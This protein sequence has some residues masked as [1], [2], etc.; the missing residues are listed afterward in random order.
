M[1]NLPVDFQVPL[2][3]VIKVSYGITY[4]ERNLTMNGEEYNKKPNKRT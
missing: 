1:T 2:S 3:K 4:K